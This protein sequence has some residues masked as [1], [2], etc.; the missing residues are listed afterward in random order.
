MQFATQLTRQCET[1]QGHAGGDADEREDEHR[2]TFRR[3]RAF[4][5][6]HIDVGERF[7]R[8]QQPTLRVALKR[9]DERRC[10]DTVGKPNRS[11]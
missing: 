5:Y 3:Y 6:R 8:G 7:R 9:V 11:P 1:D 10:I 4:E 2:L